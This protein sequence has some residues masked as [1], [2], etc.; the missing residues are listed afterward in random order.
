MGTAVMRGTAALP[1]VVSRSTNTRSRGRMKTAAARSSAAA[2]ERQDRIIQF[3]P[4]VAEYSPGLPVAP[5]RIQV[6]C[7]GEH[8]LAGPV[9]LGHLLAGVA[10]DER[11][12]V[13]RH[14][15]LL[16]LLHSDAVGGNQRHDIRSRMA[17]HGALPVRT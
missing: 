10:G 16:A 5:H 6:E 17:L 2:I 12:A 3:G 1:P 9:G 8:R 14:R 11:G 7:R 4:S 13:E 15:V